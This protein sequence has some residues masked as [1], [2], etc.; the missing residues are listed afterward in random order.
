MYITESCHGI[1]KLLSHV[2]L[3]NKL[4]VYLH[5]AEE[6][7]SLSRHLFMNVKLFRCHSLLSEM[8]EFEP[9]HRVG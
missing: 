7:N 1:N 9:E 3:T 6:I 4:E 8:I 2:V 5:A